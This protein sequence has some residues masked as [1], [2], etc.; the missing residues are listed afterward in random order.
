MDESDIAA[1]IVDCA[2]RLHQNLGPGLLET[3][4]EVTLAHKLN[5]HGLSVK[6]GI[7]RAIN[8]NLS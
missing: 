6:D 2:V 4:Y 7:S 5:A 1:V 3:A 8:G